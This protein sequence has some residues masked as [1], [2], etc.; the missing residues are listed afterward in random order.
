VTVPAYPQSRLPVVLEIAPGANLSTDPG[1]WPW[2]EVTNSWRVRDG[3]AISEGRGDW[4]QHVDAGSIAVVFDNRSGDFSQ[5]NPA[6]RWYGLLGRDTPLRVRLRRGADAFARISAAG[7][8]TADS[9]QAWSRSDTADRFTLNGTAGLHNHPTI[10]VVRRTTL[11]V[12]L[13]DCEQLVDVTAPAAITGT[14]LVTGTVHRVQGTGNTHYWLRA[15]FNAGGSQ[16]QVKISR[17]LVGVSTELAAVTPA[18]LTYTPGVPMRVRTRVVDDQL[19]IKVWPAA[20]VEPAA[21]TLTAVDKVITGP[22]GGGLQSWVVAGNTNTLPVV[23]AHTNYKLHVDLAGGYVPAWVPHWDTSGKDRTV[24]VTARGALYRLQPAGSGKPPKRSAM[25]RAIAASGAVV[26]FPVEDGPVAGQAAS[27]IPGVQAMTLAG[28]ITFANVDD[29]VFSAFGN[30]VT[31]R[32]G[33][34]RVASLAQGGQL[35]ALLPPQVAAACAGAWTAQMWGRVDTGT[36]NG[37]VVILDVTT[38]GGTYVRWQLIAKLLSVT[39]VI[40]TRADGTAAT[41]LNLANGFPSLNVW[42]LSARQNGANIDVQFF[43]GGQVP[44]ASGSVAGTLTGPTTI[45]VNSTMRTSTL[46]FPAGHVAVFPVYGPPPWTTAPLDGYGE[47]YS[48]ADLAWLSEA[49]IDRLTRLCREDGMPL[50]VAAVDE[51]AVVRMGWQPIDAP[52]PLYQQCEDTDGGVIYERPFRL[53]YQPRA[54]RYNQAPALTLDAGNDLADPPEPDG[55]GQAYRNTWTVTRIDGSSAVAQT[56]DAISGAA[57]VYDDSADLSLAD[58]TRLADQA[59]WRLHLT[60][61]TALR[62]PRLTLDLAASPQLID[63]WLNCRTGSRILASNPLADVAGTD[64]DVILEGHTTTLGHKD[65][66]VDAN[67]SPAQPWIVAV[68]GGTQRAPAQASALAGPLAA[69]GQATFSLASTAANGL[70]TTDPAAFPLELRVGGERLRV[71]AI[72]GASSPQT[73]TVDAGGRGLN[74]VQLAW[75]IGTPVDVWQPAIAPL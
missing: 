12:N 24:A 32:W 73:A 20:G 36:T 59:G 23:V 53:A 75:P 15:E 65:F 58:D 38:P 27:A 8:G 47:P 13:T 55:Q 10:N 69:T 51:P 33:T 16:M 50:S 25:R 18:G 74:G 67:C 64:I 6:G 60:S 11:G 72:T 31:T 4:G 34:S 3:I 26:Y 52:L 63:G 9:G 19:A 22:G 49:A 28:P 66:D 48:G 62:W 44:R 54:A 40:G 35:S 45:A 14:A 43:V 39:Q 57:V 29:A 56:D 68:A 7:W 17:S 5:Y 42:T 1:T 30:T 71:S 37:D 41:L 46:D 21:W 2:T 70:W 61:G